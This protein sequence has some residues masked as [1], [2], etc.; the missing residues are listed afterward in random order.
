[1][2]TTIAVPTAVQTTI[3]T[4]RFDVRKPEDKHAYNALCT[5]MAEQGTECFESWGGSGG[6]H[7]HPEW[8]GR[9]VTLETAFVFDNQWNTAPIAGISDKGLRVFDWAQ[10]Y[11]PDGWGKSI[12]QGHYLELTPEM[13]EVR[14]NRLTC[15]YCGK[16][17]DR[18]DNPPVFCDNCLG[19]QHLK[20]TELHLTRVAPVG[21]KTNREPLTAEETAVLVPRYE[22]E[23]AGKGSERSQKA[24]EQYGQRIK[25]DYEEKRQKYEIQY[26]G[27]QWLFDVGC[28]LRLMENCIYY[29]HTGVFTF[30]W[31]DKLTEGSDLDWL[32][33]N[34][35]KFPYAYTI[36]T[37]H[38]GEL[39][40]AGTE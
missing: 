14:S 40:P 30:G 21:L 34:M 6:G 15:G 26:L 35:E 31:R 29:D 13:V 38:R 11:K 1:M 4:Y 32:M 25:R 39:V 5:K 2:K 3:H 10:D 37:A 28:P 23:Q 24:R 18:R 22:A 27:K 17:Y 20:S 16:Q 36:K 7:Y 19:S 8:N 12:K 33:A 9:Q